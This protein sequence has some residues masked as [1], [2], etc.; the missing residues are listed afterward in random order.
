MVMSEGELAGAVHQCVRAL[1]R[2]NLTPWR[3]ELGAKQCGGKG[4]ARI[5]GLPVEIVP[6]D[7]YFR[8]AYKEWAEERFT[9]YDE[10]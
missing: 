3:V 8:V 6:L 7:D 5:A 4:W 10:R 1:R 9:R 2:Q